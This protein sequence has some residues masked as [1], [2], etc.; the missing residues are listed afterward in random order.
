MSEQ[1]L[2]VVDR[3]STN[4]ESSD[5]NVNFFKPKTA[6]SR[7]NMK[8]IISMVLVWVLAVFGFQVLLM[9]FNQPTPEEGYTTFESV[10]PKVKDGS[11]S[12]QEKQEFARVCLNVLGKNIVL[13]DDQKTVLKDSLTQ[14]ILGL[15]SSEQQSTITGEDTQAAVTLA[16]DVIGLQVSGFDKLRGDLLSYSMISN[17][18]E[19]YSDELPVIMEL[20]LVHNQSFLTDMRFLGFPFHYWYTAQFLLILFVGLCWIYAF[21]TDRSN[22]QYNF[23]DE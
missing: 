1:P 11:A 8:M 5:Y 14:T 4:S 2:G 20:Y 18:S 3:P 22:K 10:W 21:Q 17:P 7:A 9:V 23:P 16:K 19:E 13:T 15:V 12:V 6:H